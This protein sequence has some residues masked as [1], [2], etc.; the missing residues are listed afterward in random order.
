[1]QKYSLFDMFDHVIGT[2]EF[3]SLNAALCWK[4]EMQELLNKKL[5]L[6]YV[7]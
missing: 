5:W 1:M 3:S 2:H 7:S 6:R 4:A